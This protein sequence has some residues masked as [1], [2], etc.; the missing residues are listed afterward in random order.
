MSRFCELQGKGPHCPCDCVVEGHAP[1]LPAHCRW[2]GKEIES[3]V[4]DK[5]A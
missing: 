3:A 2:C 4:E 1:K 5:K